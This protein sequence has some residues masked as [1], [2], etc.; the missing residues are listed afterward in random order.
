MERT[1]RYMGDGVNINRW[2]NGRVVEALLWTLVLME[3]WKHRVGR[4]NSRF[5]LLVLVLL[6]RSARVLLPSS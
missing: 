2:I 6:Q 5:I 4:P 3:G 1:V